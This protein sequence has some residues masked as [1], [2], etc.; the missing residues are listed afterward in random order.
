MNH[1]PKKIRLIKLI[2]LSVQQLIDLYMKI[3]YNIQQPVMIL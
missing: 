1:N 2:L 3:K